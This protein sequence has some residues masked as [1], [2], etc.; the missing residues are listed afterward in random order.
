MFNNG[1]PRMLE[2]EK[3][4]GKLDKLCGLLQKRFYE[5]RK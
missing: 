2:E 5:N 1:G 4:D 3:K